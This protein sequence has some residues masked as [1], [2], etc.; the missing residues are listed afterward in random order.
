LNYTAKLGAGWLP[1]SLIVGA[2]LI[3]LV[4]AAIYSFA[5]LST[6]TTWV[7]H[8]DEVRVRIAQLK[9]T[10]LD[11][12]TGLRGYL[13][14]GDEAFLAPYER[15]RSTWRPQLDELRALTTDNPD[16]QA[17]LHALEGLVMDELKGLEE[18]RV[19]HPRDITSSTSLQMMR[20]RKQTMDG[21]RTV[22]AAMEAEEER[23]DRRREH[24]ANRRWLLTSALFIGGALAFVLVLARI[25]TQ[26]RVSEAR[27]QR[28]E[29]ERRLLQVV[30]ASID[31]GITLQDRSGKLIYANAGAARLIGYPS[32]DALL[33]A[34][35]REIA[36]RFEIFDEEGRPFPADKLPSQAALSGRP[37]E[38]VVIRYRIDKTS[39]WKWS[40]VQAHPVTDA[41]GN[42]TQVINLFRDVTADREADERSR[43]MLR[44]V[45]ELNSSLDYEAT[46][47][48]IARLAVPALADWCGVDI[49]VEGGQL[50]RLAVAHVDP[51]KLES[52]VEL[53]RRYPPD[54]SSK[55][56]VHEIIRTGQPQLMPEIPRELL[57]AAAVDEDH[58][59]LIDALELRSF[60]G[61]PLLIGG[62]VLGAITFVMAESRRTYREADL[63]FARGLA[64]R[65]A[66]AIEN[67][68][69]FREVESARAAV[70]AQLAVEER[71]RH[72]AEEQARFAE[73]FVGMLGHDLRNPLNAIV[74]TTR[75]LRRIAQ[76]PH[77]ITAVERVRS[78]AQ[79][80][81]NMVGQLL[82]LTRSRIAG[83]ITIERHPVDLCLVISEAVDELRRAY[84]GREIAWSGGAGVHTMADRDRLAQVF[85]NL[86]GNALEHG[87]PARPVTVDLSTAGNGFTLAVH[88]DGPPI[89]S[90]F[91]PYLF[92]PFRRTVVRNE[93]SKGLGLGLFITEQ[94]V[95]AHGGRIHVSSTA[96]HGTTFSVFL[97]L[98]DAELLASPPQQLVS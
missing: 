63:A 83:G 88:N 76:A 52:A 95:H 66:L 65:A 71:R 48:T 49:V 67:A 32:V 21:L 97:P 53:S 46:L 19:A 98:S 84:P 41:A 60:M 54:P 90:E 2:V 34:S 6:A 33:S 50:K 7:R 23:L 20:A 62:K 37:P 27:R 28:A 68:R 18:T 43:F 35:G 22:L 77:E 85:S 24:S 74:M 94:I 12:E 15:A 30:F 40:V 5:G 38:R 42:V 92:E 79:R 10:L 17:R 29:E 64:D 70:A 93:R 96:E 69:L 86:I 4:A 55:T 3:A 39:A 8:T 13:L 51:N 59:K 9:S 80:M 58:L 82:D 73:T 61:V 14:T 75:L 72:E 1:R 11:A 81:S 78:S 25:G 57:R 16:Q 89:A 45:D 87:D 44:A 47:A 36:D 31:D 56:G 91:L 26:R